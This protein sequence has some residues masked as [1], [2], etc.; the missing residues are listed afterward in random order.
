MSISVVRR[1][2]AIDLFAGAGG[3][4]LGLEQAGFDVLAAVDHDPVHVAVHRFNAPLT[5]TVCGS[6]TTLT[7]TELLAAAAAG[8]EA[9]H[10]GVGWDGRVD[11]VAGGPPCQGFSVGGKQDPADTRND[12]VEHFRRLVREVRPRYVL[13][14]NVPGLMSRPMAPVLARL[15]EGFTAD[16]WTMRDPVVLN[17]ADFGVPQSRRRV[18]LL[19]S[20][21]GEQ[22][23]PVPVATHRPAARTRPAS[24]SGDHLPVGPTVAD[25]LADLPDLDAFDELLLTDRVRPPG[26]PGGG[27]SASGYARV[28][29]G[30]DDD[31]ADLSHPRAWD[32]TW[33]TG[34]ARTVHGPESVARFTATPPGTAEPISRF[35]RLDPDGLCNTL[36]AGTDAGHGAHTSPRPLHPHLPR[37]ISV[38]EA[39]RLHSLPDWFR[40]HSTKAHGF[41]EIGNSVPPLL[42]RAVGRAVVIALGVEPGRPEQA[43]LLGDP[44]L[45]VLSPSGAAAFLGSDPANLPRRDRKTQPG[46]AA[47]TGPV[48]LHTST[49]GPAVPDVLVPGRRAA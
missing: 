28:L 40:A 30:T 2:V 8:W 16:G 41:R 11:L 10:P 22:P 31:P 20:A 35:L 14:E 33:L 6:A 19:G 38:R 29:H 48:G 24:R 32:R 49:T 43:V 27:A 42:A 5:E 37:V 15:L 44:A 23:V 36:R 21:P 13:M 17:A 34:S 7:G 12:L 25:A 9:H 4:S 3:L 47:G 18:F 46:P 26:G 39:A 45:L 1:P